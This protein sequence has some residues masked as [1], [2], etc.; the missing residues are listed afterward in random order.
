MPWQ[1]RS[2]I[3]PM[4]R[5]QVILRLAIGAVFPPVLGS[6]IV[7]GIGFLSVL[8]FAFVFVGI[9]A[10]IY[11]LVMEFFVNRRIHSLPASLVC[12]LVLGGLSGVVP[13]LLLGLEFMLVGCG[14]ALVVGFGLRWLMMSAILPSKQI[15]QL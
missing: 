1:Y 9:Q 6:I 13:A 3:G 8:P 7:G 12:A 14:V 10:L 4:N 2:T 11:S 5:S 15:E